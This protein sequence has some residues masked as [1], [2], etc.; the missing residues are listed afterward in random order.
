MAKVESVKDGE[1]ASSSQAAL[2][3]D[4]QFT[5]LMQVWIAIILE[6]NPDIGGNNTK[7]KSLMN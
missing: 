3:L 5:E 2:L 7:V 6:K 4:L 1:I